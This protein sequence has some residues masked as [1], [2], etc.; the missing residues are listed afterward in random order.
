MSSHLYPGMH[1]RSRI[2]FSSAYLKTNCTDLLYVGQCSRVV[3]EV[4]HTVSRPQTIDHPRGFY[5]L[6]PLVIHCVQKTK[7]VNAHTMTS[8][9]KL[10]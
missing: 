7:C 6:E 8:K 1:T 10:R 3:R 2:A 4:L 5:A 9:A